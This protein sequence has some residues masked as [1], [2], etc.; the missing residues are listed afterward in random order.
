M[1]K[2]KPG[3]V[4]GQRARDV[5]DKAPEILSSIEFKT[6]FGAI[7]DADLRRIQ[8]NTDNL[9]G[10]VS[11]LVME[12]RELREINEMLREHIGKL[13]L[14]VKDLTLQ[15]KM[16]DGEKEPNQNEAADSAGP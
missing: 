3:R 6:D 9:H 4:I 1:D 13:S 8:T 10:S 12:N 11:D 7:S 15:L 5:A 14:S 2:L 16:V